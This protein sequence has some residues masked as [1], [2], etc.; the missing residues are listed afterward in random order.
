VQQ[1]PGESLRSFIQWFSHVCNTIPRIT[2]ASVIVAFHQGVRDEEMLEKLT[3]HDIQDVVEL[4]TLADKCTRAA[5]GRAWHTSPAPEVGKGGKPNASTAAQGGGSK[6]KNNNK[7][8]VSDNNQLL[9]G[10][11]IAVVAA[12]TAGG[13]RGPQGDKRPHQASGNDDGGVRC[14]V[15]NSKC[16]NAEEC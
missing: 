2:N 14:P 7:K 3:M 5:K 12:A 6:N 16:H 8:K 13:S 15:H 1:R 11:P 10:A 4:F 9:I